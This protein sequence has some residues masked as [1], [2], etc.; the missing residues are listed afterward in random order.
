MSQ[1]DIRHVRSDALSGAYLF[2]VHPLLPGRSLDWGSTVIALPA[3]QT[4]IGA[5]DLPGPT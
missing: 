3:E 4:S 5:T 2:L 1:G